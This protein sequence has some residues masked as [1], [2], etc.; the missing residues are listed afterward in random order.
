M[1]SSCCLAGRLMLDEM[2]TEGAS[3]RRAFIL[4]EE[5][6]VKGLTKTRMAKTLGIVMAGGIGLLGCV[7]GMGR[8]S[9]AMP[10]TPSPQ[11]PSAI[12]ETDAPTLGE[13]EIRNRYAAE[14][15][16]LRHENEQCT[17]EL[18]RY[19]GWVNAPENLATP[20]PAGFFRVAKL[21]GSWWFVT[22]E[23]H[24]FVSKGVTDVNWL[25][26][27]LS[28]G[29]FHDT[30]VQ[31]YGTEEVW[32]DAARARL[33]KWG[34]NTAGPWSSHSMAS[35][36]SHCV[37]IL[38]AAGAN[39][40]RYPG[41]VVT[42]YWSPDF[43]KHVR[44]VSTQRAAPFVEDKNLIGYFLDNE[45]VWGS[46]HFRTKKTLLQLYMDFPVDAP[47]RAEARRFLRESVKSV[48]QFNQIWGTMLSN[49]SGIEGLS[50]KDLKPSTE[51]AR[52][53]TQEFTLAVF[54]KYAST[55]IPILRSVD[56]N[57]LI[58]G[59]RFHTYPGDALIQAASEYFDVI[60]MAFYEA[61]PPVKE[62][63]AICGRV[64]K[65]FLI[66]E[67]TFKSDDSGLRNMGIY[68]PRV[69][70]QTERC[71][72]YLDYVETFMRRPYAIGFHWYKLMDNPFKGPQ[73]P[74]SADNCGLVN[75]KDEAYEPFVEFVS[76][77]NRRVETWHAESERG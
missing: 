31:K 75:E 54:R 34:Y 64:D 9:P 23:G 37:I 65:P 2:D 72:S 70:T 14:Q 44:E 21:A 58:L 67:W 47:G 17:M 27:S 40:P 20:P 43:A 63:D 18:D 7:G 38:D 19:G 25:G 76:E 71:L 39:S 50:S 73:E 49:W 8:R 22:P 32:A 69:K 52:N 24:P 26:A 6:F 33:L 42:D 60:S 59:C 56:P 61:R 15:A 29:P 36:I 57:H 77:V 45:L 30:I 35:R 53:T 5:R 46:D 48:R 62:M 28:E 51:E 66:E 3:E 41:S 10:E 1:R 74:F 4:K 68:A 16:S 13:E 11:K 55:V 12:S